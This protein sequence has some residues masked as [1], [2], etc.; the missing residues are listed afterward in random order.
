MKAEVK[1]EVNM[2][3]QNSMVTQ[4][5]SKDDQVEYERYKCKIQRCKSDLEHLNGKGELAAQGI[6]NEEDD[7]LSSSSSS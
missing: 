5:S 7:V 6:V 1:R 2:R 4:S 3:N